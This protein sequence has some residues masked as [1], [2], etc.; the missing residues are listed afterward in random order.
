MRKWWIS[1]AFILLNGRVVFAQS[2]PADSMYLGQIPPGSTPKPLN[3]F[4]NPATFAA[5]RIAI[6]NDG[7]EIYYTELRAYF[8]TSGDTIR[9]YRYTDGGWTGPFDVFNDYL[10]PALSTS[11]D[12]MFLQNNSE[13]YETFFSVRNGTNWSAPRRILNGLNSAH[14][15]Q[16]T[17]NG[18]YFVSSRSGSGI[19]GN[20]WCRLLINGTDTTAVSL[21]LPLN[22]T[23]DNLDFFVARDESFMIIAKGG[24]HI[25]YPTENG[26]W[27]NPKSLDSQINFGAGMWGPYVSADHQYL[28]YSTGTLPD[29]SDVH[30]YW[31]RIDSLINALRHTNFVP[32]LKSP[33]PDR[34]DTVGR[35]FHY[36]LPD[37]F[38]VDDDGSQTLK[39]SATLSNGAPL[40]AWLTFDSLSRTFSG[41]P[42]TTGFINIKVKV[43]DTAMASASDFFRLTT[44]T[45]PTSIDN[46]HGRVPDRLQLYPNFPNPFNPSTTIS[47][48]VP[49]GGHVTL[50]V[51]NAAGQLVTTLVDQPVSAGRHDVRWNAQPLAS[52]L[53]FC[54]IQAGGARQSQRMILLK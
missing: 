16:V 7:K 4:E 21:G 3:M 8:P 43:T 33:V 38:F 53:Y 29:Y 48:D 20:D 25:S 2:I 6:S 41:M 10:A 27:T 51:Y 36:T 11:G 24:L 31:V 14:Y 49:E 28:F 32:Y 37:T 18:N 15:L 46:S 34:V 22:S 12:T 44:V 1:V 19:G 45:N 9:C 54:M 47:F 50:R 40:P 5:E 26:R 30:V 23:A 35:L 42:T 52:G 39:Y 17:G 13:I